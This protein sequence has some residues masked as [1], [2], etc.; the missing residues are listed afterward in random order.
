MNTLFNPCF[1]FRHISFLDKLCSTCPHQKLLFGLQDSVIVTVPKLTFRALLDIQPD[2]YKH[3]EK[4]QFSFILISCCPEIL[5]S[6]LALPVSF[7]KIDCLH[8]SFTAYENFYKLSKMNCNLIWFSTIQPSEVSE[9]RDPTIKH[10][11]IHTLISSSIN[12]YVID[13]FLVILFTY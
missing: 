9:N 1:N 6:S 13:L 10:I 4:L 7:L 8:V 3:V 2:I 12:T 11:S 5:N